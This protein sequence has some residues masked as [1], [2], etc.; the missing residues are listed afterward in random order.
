MYFTF[1]SDQLLNYKGTKFCIWFWKSRWSHMADEILSWSD[2][3]FTY[4]MPCNIRH[5]TEESGHYGLHTTEVFR[6]VLILLSKI[7]LLEKIFWIFSTIWCAER[8][9]A[10]NVGINPFYKWVILVLWE[11]GCWSRRWEVL[12]I[13]A[14]FITLSHYKPYPTSFKTNMFTTL[15]K[16]SKW[17]TIHLHY[18]V[19]FFQ[20]STFSNAGKWW[21]WGLHKAGSGGSQVPMLRQW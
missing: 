3:F 1:L 7:Q 19:Y 6:L 14:V 13:R 16:P 4:K 10:L 12:L 8:R 9:S 2:L 21:A 20:G 17:L 11:R 15:T 18:Q 5:K